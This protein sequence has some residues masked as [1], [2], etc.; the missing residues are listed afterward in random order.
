MA[1]SL[2]SSSSIHQF[3][4]RCLESGP[5]AQ[6]WG[7]GGGGRKGE[8]EHLLHNGLGQGGGPQVQGHPPAPY[9]KT[10]V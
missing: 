1:S 6:L 2:S 3:L 5:G 7:Q 9:E 4:N 10:I 8:Q